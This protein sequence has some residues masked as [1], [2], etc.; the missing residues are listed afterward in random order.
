MQIFSRINS[1]REFYRIKFTSAR[2][3]YRYFIFELARSRVGDWSFGW[4]NFTYDTRIGVYSS[5]SRA[6]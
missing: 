1:E 2:M 6:W 4:K 5:E 3:V